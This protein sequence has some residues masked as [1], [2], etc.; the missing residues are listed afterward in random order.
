[1][2][3]WLRKYTKQIMVIVVL[4]AMFSFVGGSA[5]VSF[6]SPNLDKEP[7]AR[8]FGHEI[9]GLDKRPAMRDTQILKT[10]FL[11]WQ[12][13]MPNQR[14]TVDHWLLLAE[15][16]ERAGVV[17][18][19]QEVEE[20][21]KQITDFAAMRGIPDMLDYLRTKEAITP[22]EVRR[23]IRRH[24]AIRHHSEHLGGSSIPSEPQLR[25]YAR[26]TAEKVKIEYVA[27]DAEKFINEKQPVTDAELAL[28]YSQYKD[29]V[30]AEGKSDFGY[31]Y[32]RRVKVQ[33]IVADLSKLQPLLTVTQEEAVAFWRANRAKY[34]KNIYVPDPAASQ[35]TSGP[36]I[37]KPEIVEQPFTE[38]RPSVEREL[39]KR[40]AM[41]VSEQAMR[42]AVEALSKP[43]RDA[44]L[45]PETGY[46]AIPA[47]ANDPEAMKKLCER[48]SKELGATFDYVETG[49]VS[50]ADLYNHPQLAALRV[51]EEEADISVE[52]VAFRVPMFHTP[53]KNSETTIRLQ[54][55][56]PTEAPLR[57]YMEIQIPGRPPLREVLRLGVMRVV[58]S[59]ESQ[60]PVSIEEIRKQLTHDVLL[61]R[62]LKGLEAVSIELYAA[63]RK[64]GLAEALKMFPEIKEKAEITSPT[65]P[66]PFARKTFLMGD[67]AQLAT[68]AGESKLT[69]PE[70]DGVGRS[71]EFVKACFE[72]TAPGFVPEEIP[73][74]QNDRFKKPTTQPVSTPPVAKRLCIPRLRKCFVVQLKEVMKVDEE[75][76]ENELRMSAYYNLLRERA[77]HLE[78]MWFAPA[79]IEKRC[80]FSR[81]EG[82]EPLFSDEGYT[83]PRREAPPMF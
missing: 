38:A 60:S 59:V 80:E 74:P 55:W 29:F 48:L 42:Q 22:P 68:L 19:D 9:T 21:L 35:P 32:P 28:Q 11:D 1:M 31:K 63:A 46:K 52:K 23:A 12:Y 81:I 17:V 15:E 34:K 75:K 77:S 47:G 69:T 24:L 71:E 39:R 14:M 8:A 78:A 37:T 82:A 67:E 56:Q 3:K 50:E 64:F 30:A 7:Y 65:A 43:W 5:L 44:K 40:K 6:L 54:L 18:T 53:E 45:D 83:G 57:A 61:L 51:P 33:A 72:M 10:L 79:A 73:L 76:Y 66:P 2:I 4:I 62:T 58:E 26:D 13:D 27:L 16:A 70:V 41:Q 36:A 20:V 25:H 49:L